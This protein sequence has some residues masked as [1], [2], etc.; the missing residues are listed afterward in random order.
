MRSP[1]SAGVRPPL[2]DVGVDRSARRDLPPETAV[3]A[4]HALGPGAA[5]G[6]SSG[7]VDPAAATRPGRRVA[8]VVEAPVRALGP[9][10]ATGPSSGSVDQVCATGLGSGTVVH[11]SATGPGSG[12]ELAEAA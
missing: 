4:A 1:D 2:Q 3:A 10:A 12:K 5:T 11:A 8:E 7:L 6:P 9:G